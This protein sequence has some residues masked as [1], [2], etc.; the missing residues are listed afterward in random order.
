MQKNYIRRLRV[1]VV[2]VKIEKIKREL[3]ELK[4]KKTISVDD[5]YKIQKLQQQL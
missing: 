4:T 3:L 5:K 1:N 2:S